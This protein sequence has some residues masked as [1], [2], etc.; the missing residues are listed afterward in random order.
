MNYCGVY[1]GG[2]NTPYLLKKIKKTFLGNFLKQILSLNVPI[3]GG[4]AGAIVFGKSI[5]SSLL[6]DKNWNELK[7][8]QGFDLL[9]G[10]DITCHYS[11]K[12]YT[13]IKELIKI[14]KIIGLIA[15]TERN[16]LYV[17]NEGIKVIGKKNVL[18]ITENVERE[19]SVGEII[20]KIL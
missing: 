4:S 9:G 2:G 8:L 20:P 6:Y 7:D 19:F 11:K 1:I 10:Y 18:C 15:L 14:N 13:K 16:G 17:N 5:F 12:E 3:Y